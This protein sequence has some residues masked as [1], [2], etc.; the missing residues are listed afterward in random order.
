MRS[1]FS[2]RMNKYFALIYLICEFTYLEYDCAKKKNFASRKPFTKM[3]F[4]NNF[5]IRVI[6]SKVFALP[7]GI[8]LMNIYYE[9]FSKLKKILF[10]RINITR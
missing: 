2:F 10:F 8:V 6:C 3:I 7:N 5:A 4:L 1:F 9:R